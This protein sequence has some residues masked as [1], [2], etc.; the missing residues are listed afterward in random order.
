MIGGGREGVG[1]REGREGRGEGGR[2]GGKGRREGGRGGGREEGIGG[3]REGERGGRETHISGCNVALVIFTLRSSILLHILTCR[4]LE[5][6][7]ESS[8]ILYYLSVCL[9]NTGTNFSEF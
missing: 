3:R 6:G 7:V 9:L 5:N 8:Y 2:E 1:E 4:M